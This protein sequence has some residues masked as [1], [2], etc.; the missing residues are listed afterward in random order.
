MWVGVGLIVLLCF[1]VAFLAIRKNRLIPRTQ[2]TAAATLAPIPQVLPATALPEPNR[3]LS[4]PTIQNASP[5]LTAAMELAA[6]NPNDP[7][8]HVDLSIALV[9]AKEIRPAMEELAQAANL[10]GP[11][12]KDFILKS[13]DKF[14]VRELWVPAAS[15]Y[16]RLVPLYRKDMPKEVESKLYEA[17]YK[18]TEQ[19]DMP[20]FVV[21]ERVE[22][23]SP[24]LGH[25]ARGRY[26]LYNG[27]MEEAKTQLANAQ[28]SKPDM[29][30]IYLLKAEIEMKSGNQAEAK[31]ILLSLTSALEAPEWIRFMAENYLKTIP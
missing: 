8:A 14:A 9:E 23:A 28:K 26:A 1:A 7:D 6:K 24:S 3:P 11:N 29:Y 21:F 12:N 2:P 19:K 27:S 22:N 15:M 10:A 18:S 17:V 31:N 20:L 5:E 4:Q 16:L 25:I 13:A 30:E